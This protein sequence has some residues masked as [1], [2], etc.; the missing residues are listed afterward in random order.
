MTRVKNKPKPKKCEHRS[1]I[2]LGLDVNAY[3]VEWCSL[4]GA[5]ERARDNGTRYWTQP[6][7]SR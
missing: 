1:P 7:A 6:G 3:V 5:V 2:R 4:C